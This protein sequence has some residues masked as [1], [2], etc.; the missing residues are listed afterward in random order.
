[1]LLLLFAA[2]VAAEHAG[3]PPQ[4]ACAHMAHVALQGG[5]LDWAWS[6]GA[7]D[8]RTTAF[9]GAVVAAAAWWRRA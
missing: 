6:W 1:M 8:A 5:I 9:S 7:A 3:A 2:V 4:R